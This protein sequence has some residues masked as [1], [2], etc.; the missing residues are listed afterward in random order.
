MRPVAFRCFRCLYTRPCFARD[1]CTVT[2]DIFAFKPS[3]FQAFKKDN[4]VSKLVDVFGEAGSVSELKASPTCDAAGA[5]L[6]HV[7]PV[8]LTPM[9]RFK[10]LAIP[11]RMKSSWFQRTKL[12]AAGSVY[13]L[14][15]AHL[16]HARI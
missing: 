5:L 6:C 12:A 8:S 1:E 15:A 14:V 13:T 9:S 11:S 4:I 16:L 7:L 10:L 2:Q 3:A